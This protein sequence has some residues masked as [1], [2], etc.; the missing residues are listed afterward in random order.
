[1]TLLTAQRAGSPTPALAKAHHGSHAHLVTQVDAKDAPLGDIDAV[2]VPT[3]RRSSCLRDSIELADKLGCQLLALC[4]RESR[5]ADVVRLGF[6]MDVRVDAV[7]FSP[8]LLPLDHSSARVGLKYTQFT[9]DSDLS[10][11]RN[12]GLLL[13]RML[14]WRRVLFL[15]DDITRIATSDVRAAAGLLDSY[16]AVGLENHGFP[17]NSVVCHAHR[18]TGGWQ[19]T[20]VSG[21][22]LAIA[23]DRVD[24]FFPDIYNED[25][26]FLCGVAGIAVTGSACQMHYDPFFD[27]DR[28]RQEEFGDFLAE[29]LYWLRDEGWPAAEADMAFWEWF[30]DMVRRGL[31]HEVLAKLCRHPANAQ[32]DRMI[33]SLAAAQQASRWITPQLCVEFIEAWQHDR[34]CWRD[35]LASLPQAASVEEAVNL[36]ERLR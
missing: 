21:G 2:V 22:M 23:A 33:H 14:G 16:D 26:F 27:P 1:M 6:D 13:G 18:A 19:D 28:A 35:L 8:D 20:F 32:R 4:S 9:H 11:K 34:R 36:L 30:L 5:A 17:D 25:W 29:G 24:E 12:L 15:D 3:V 7:D 10:G 31:I